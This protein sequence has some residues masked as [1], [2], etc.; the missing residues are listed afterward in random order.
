MYLEQST[1][2]LYKDWKTSKLEDKWRL[3]RLQHCWD[4][5][6]YVEESERQDETCCH[7]ISS[8]KPSANAGAKNF[9][10]SI[11]LLLLLLIIIKLIPTEIILVATQNYI[12]LEFSIIE[13]A[14]CTACSTYTVRCLL[15]VNYFQQWS[16]GYFISCIL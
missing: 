16:P 1:K 9:Q 6:E 5:P 14:A 8:E 11:I 2:G 4:R 3:P 12:D 15:W 7:S 10:K 13:V